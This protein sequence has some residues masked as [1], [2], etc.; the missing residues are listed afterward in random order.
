MQ[1]AKRGKCTA[2]DPRVRATRPMGDTTS[3]P[4]ILD[5]DHNLVKRLSKVV[6]MTPWLEW[7]NPPRTPIRTTGKTG[8]TYY[9]CSGPHITAAHATHQS[10]G[11]RSGREIFLQYLY[12]NLRFFSESVTGLRIMLR[13]IKYRSIVPYTFPSHP[14]TKP[15]DCT[16]FER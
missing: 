5:Y 10:V 3:T 13:E 16:G 15:V 8:K 11:V 14:Q 2:R 6:L 1:R 9:S 12:C 4:T 7:S